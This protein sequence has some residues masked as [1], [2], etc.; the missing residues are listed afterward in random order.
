MHPSSILPTPHGLDTAHVPQ[1]G[2][3]LRSRLRRAGLAIWR[4]LEA[5]GNDRAMREL[6]FLQ[7]QW[8]IS[9]PELARQLLTGIEAV[10]TH[11]RSG[12]R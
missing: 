10:D 5:S 8:E 2:A 6:R 9:D 1:H 12:S 4:A 3:N 11:R 7:G